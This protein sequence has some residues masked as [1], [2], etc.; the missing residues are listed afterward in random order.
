MNSSNLEVFT[1]A[2]GNNPGGSVK[3]HM[4][5]HELLELLKAGSLKTN[6]WVSEVSSGSTALSLAYYSKKFELSCHLFVPLQM[7]EEKKRQLESYGARIHCYA[8]DVIYQKHAEFLK[9]HPK[10]NFF[11]QLWDEKKVRHYK[12]LGQHFLN[13]CG[14]FDIVMGAVGTGH[15]LKGVAQ[16]NSS[17]QVYTAE[18]EPGDVCSGVR[19]ISHDRYGDE[20][21][22][23]PEQFSHRIILN[24]KN[25]FP[26]ETVETDQGRLKISESFR[27]VLGSINTLKQF[28]A[29]R[30]ILALGA[31]NFFLTY[32]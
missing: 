14:P 9:A 12:V 27:L 20:D 30:R 26:N 3:D 19:N 18:P 23:R 2:E 31:Q 11:N 21:P 13:Q 17:A 29:P 1:S 24:K 22:C 6:D 28:T 32:K 4:V 15:S 25:Y 10:T 7:P 5:Y 8:T 16:V